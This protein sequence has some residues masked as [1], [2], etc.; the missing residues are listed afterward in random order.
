MP[1]KFVWTPELHELYM[2]AVDKLGGPE[3]GIATPISILHEMQKLNQHSGRPLNLESLKLFNLFSY[4]VFVSRNYTFFRAN[5][6]QHRKIIRV[7]YIT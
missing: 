2:S 4:E 7:G 5:I 1:T 3:V 6:L